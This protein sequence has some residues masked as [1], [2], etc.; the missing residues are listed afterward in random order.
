MMTW[1]L[2]RKD[3]LLF[4]HEA[5]KGTGSA[6]PFLSGTNLL[7]SELKVLKKNRQRSPLF[8]CALFLR[9]KTNILYAILTLEEAGDAERA[10]NSLHLV[11]RNNYVATWK[12]EGRFSS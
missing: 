5:E 1:R 4:L 3:V 7:A 9:L 6:S 11:V 2:A 10:A 8:L 12:K